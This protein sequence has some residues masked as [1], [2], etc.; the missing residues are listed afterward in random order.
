MIADLEPYPTTRE[1]G[2]PALGNVPKHWQVEPLA[3][4]G[5]LFKGRGASKDDE[6]SSGIPCVRYGD[7]YTQHEF[8]I[9]ATRGFVSTERAS[10]YSSIKHGD[11][12]FAAS[13]ETIEDIGRSAVN[14]MPGDACC[15]GDVIVL[16]PTID[17]NPRFLG[18]AADGPAARQQKATM[19]RGFTVVHIYGSELKHLV[20]AL[21]PVPEQN[22]IVHFLDHVGRRIRRYVRAKQQLIKLLEEQRQAIIHRGVTRGVDQQVRLRPSGVDWVGDVPEH[23]TTYRLRDTIRGCFNGVWGEEPDGQDDLVCVRVADF[24]RARRRVSVDRP[25]LRAIAPSLRRARLLQR[26]DLL[27]EKSGGGDQQP[28]GMVVLYDHDIGAVCSN[29]VAR[30]PVAEGFDPRY[31]VYVHE[32]LYAIRLNA[33]SIKQTT[34]IQNL[35][36][37]AYLGERMAFPPPSEQALIVQLLDCET[38]RIAAG[39]DSARSAIGLLREFSVRMVAD[40][41]TGKLD[42][43]DAAA[44]LP[45]EIEPLD[46]DTDQDLEEAE[47]DLDAEMVEVEA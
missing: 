1:S 14:L 25:T 39:I 40:V 46:E 23:W 38:A 16:R 29:F 33:R 8:F 6:T 15:G 31:L 28:V 10:A 34:G 47:D 22:S 12:L 41:V 42:V 21:P 37:D 36:S 27:I 5:R 11:V 19:G 13:G 24:E 4:I 44:R 30:M 17:V 2:Y 35:D 3:R 9:T 20:L 7:L 32:C 26:G 45:A 18:Y 43:R